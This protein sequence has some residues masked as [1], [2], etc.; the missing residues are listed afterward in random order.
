MGLAS[1]SFVNS[2]LS[3]DWGGYGQGP[4]AYPIP[5]P[6]YLGRGM[7]RDQARGRN[8]DS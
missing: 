1:S 6:T 4:I 7:V 5:P 8:R 3:S 2:S